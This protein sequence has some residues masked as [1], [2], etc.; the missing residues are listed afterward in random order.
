V[1]GSPV[2]V[3]NAT[4]PYANP[5]MQGLW[6]GGPSQNGWGLSIMQHDTRFFMV[7]FA[8]D[9]EGHATWFVAPDG[10]WHGN[11]PLSSIESLVYRAHGSPYFNYDASSFRVSDPFEWITQQGRRPDLRTA[12]NEGITVNWL[13]LGHAS[14]GG[15]FILRNYLTDYAVV[16]IA[17]QQFAGTT[18][19]PLTGLADMWWG[20]PSQAGWGVAIHEQFGALF[21]VWF[22][23][24]FYGIPTWFVMP[25]GTWVDSRT[26]AGDV[27]STT[28]SPFGYLG[29]TYDGSR[30]RTTKVG[31][32][33]F[34]FS[35]KNNA[36]M[37]Y[38]VE[39]HVGTNT[40]VRQPF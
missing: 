1:V 32:Y 8:Y 14:L 20:G 17:P 10:R 21:S 31:T 34:V 27:Y 12:P 29:Q 7:L 6:W 9:Q 3:L 35:D 5:D 26:Y 16:P 18:A 36:T 25:G 30:L 4:F 38:D 37:H 11:L 40:L 24:D 39:G 23:Y 2:S 28:S 22:T 19:S 33:R 13:D 15:D